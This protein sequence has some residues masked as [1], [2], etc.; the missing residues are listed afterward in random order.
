M[1]GQFS[2]L[3]GGS[4]RA[5]RNNAQWLAGLKARLMPGSAARGIAY[6]LERNGRPDEALAA[7][8]GLPA[9]ERDRNA[10]FRLLLQRARRRMQAQAWLEA[11]EDFEALLKLDPHDYRAIR[12]LESA[13]LRAARQAQ[14]ERKWLIASRMWSAY[15]RAGG[16]AEKSSRN[17]MQCARALARSA[18]TTERVTELLEA[19][20]RLAAAD[21]NSRE[22]KQGVEWC[23][24]RLAFAAEKAGS[25]GEAHRRW[26]TL[27]E[28]APD[29]HEALDGLKRT[30]EFATEE[31]DGG[32]ETA[33]APGTETISAPTAPAEG[34]RESPSSLWKKF[35]RLNKHDYRAQF[36][37]GRVLQ[38]TGSPE[39][40]L[41][42][43]AS[44]FAV[45]PTA[46]AAERM[47]ACQMAIGRYVDALETLKRILAIGGY[48]TA[49]A[50][51]FAELLQRMKPGALAPDLLANLV[52]TLGSNGYVAP[53]L[54]PHLL[55]A[56]QHEITAK[57]VDAEYAEAA[58]LSEGVA[59][60]IVAYFRARSDKRR[61]LRT[62]CSYG[63]G[64]PAVLNLL[65]GLAE[66][67]SAE[68]LRSI[69]LGDASGAISPTSRSWTSHLGV[70]ELLARLG[71]DS[72]AL[73]LL[74]EL[75]ARV[76]SSATAEYYAQN[77]Q[78]ISRLVAQIAAKPGDERGVRERLAQ[79]VSVW[80][81]PLVKQ[82][83][84]GEAWTSLALDLAAAARLEEA[85]A[86]SKSGRLREGYFAHHIERRDGQD[87]DAPTSDG[88][89][90]E[91]ALRYFAVLSRWTGAE[92]IPISQ[93]LKD[94][95]L[96]SVS[97]PAEERCIDVLMAHAA[98]RD[99]P[100]YAKASSAGFEDLAAWYV[101][102]FAP[103][104][105]VPSALLSPSIRDYFNHVIARHR[106]TGLAVTRLLQTIWSSSEAY[107]RRYDLQNE[108][109][110]ALFVL[111][112]IASE[113]SRVPQYRI[114]LRG[115]LH[116][117]G[118]GT[119]RSFI[120]D[121][122]AATISDSRPGQAVPADFAVLRPPTLRDDRGPQI[123]SGRQD[124]LLI[125]HASKDTGLGRNF[126]MLADS[127]RAD[128]IALQTLDYEMEARDLGRELERW[129][130]TC[131]SS[132]VVLLAVNAQDVP[133]IFVKDRAAVL[134][135]SHTVGFF[136]W[137]TSE[138]PRVQ[139]LGIEL[140][141]EIWA[142]TQYVA[143]VYARFAPTHMVGKGLYRGSLGASTRPEGRAATVPFKFLTVFNFDSSIERKNPLA[144]VE[145]FK[146]AFP[147][148]ENVQ[149]I[150]KTSNVNPGHWSNA[151]RHW[152]RLTAACE[153]DTRI[154]LLLL[155]YPEA[156]MEELI[157]ESSCLV[158]L[159]RSEGFAYV[160]ADAM[161]HG[162]PVIATNYSGNV[163]FC[164]EETFFPVAYDLIAIDERVAH[165]KA[166]GAK[167]A[168]PN[169]KAAAE[170][171]RRVHGDY[172]AALRIAKA[173][174]QSVLSKYSAEIFRKNLRARIAT[175]RARERQVDA[176][177]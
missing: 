27:L 170:Q 10:I 82:F 29:S 38:E 4:V 25:L 81:E 8:L 59:E 167:W 19:W 116:S 109:D 1:N 126:K 62:G 71:Q 136:L 127:L 84:A 137:E 131:R 20:S 12:G 75:K 78:R 174:Q 66:T 165:W 64:S 30:Q 117:E 52:Q 105:H 138:A 164:S 113:I 42:Y 13:S 173:A 18:E 94:R 49:L 47:F 134:E 31:P 28:L 48:N 152:E 6:E 67:C 21:R 157:R 51:Q 88:E 50:R 54:L 41:P 122:A 87:P 53:V 5:L 92:S 15:H 133:A 110:T 7:W 34:A 32:T 130:S 159:H 86:D 142:P 36:H 61:A 151:L 149:L 63:G 83:F 60:E 95:L 100:Q 150:V 56:G 162:V 72:E 74:C 123:A 89:L 148:G 124:L 58:V 77:K 160:I 108:I 46:E 128:G 79:F 154:K 37:A 22:A 73:R 16:E 99:R 68:E 176:K 144:A 98:S 91:T 102:R 172:Q 114:F 17:L 161:A 40:A 57:L 158:S 33:T 69:V 111:E 55:A 85:P 119:A 155:H 70:A 26:R 96:R 107:Q 45:N 153:G 39:R 129:R 97:P 90:C 139:R 101:L 125:G 168:D 3:M 146:Q 143:E 112:V 171:M 141:D 35:S 76:P 132:P 11:A 115:I 43:F 93:G 140:V 103:A 145:A 14:A 175:I 177:R 104:N 166:E 135:I 156:Q 24:A 23:H 121:C 169:A 9:D 106:I 44:A 120:D 80:A 163:D 2:N 65:A 118:D 147:N